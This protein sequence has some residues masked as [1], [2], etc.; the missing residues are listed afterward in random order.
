[1]YF[2]TW[3]KHWSLE[4]EILSFHPIFY[5]LHGNAISMEVLQCALKRRNVGFILDFSELGNLK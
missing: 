3:E 5:L 4:A 2:I 1:M